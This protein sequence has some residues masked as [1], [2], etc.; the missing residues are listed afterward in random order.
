MQ[1]MADGRACNEHVRRTVNYVD[2][3]VSPFY[4]LGNIRP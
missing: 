4:Y 3:N 1:T 2:D